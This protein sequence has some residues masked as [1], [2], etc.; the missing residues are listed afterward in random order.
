MATQ[1]QGAGGLN[2]PLLAAGG[3]GLVA[4]L[5]VALMAL[6]TQGHAAFNTSNDGVVWG[7]PVA[8]YVFFV[9]TSTGLT[10]VAS[11]AMVFNFKEFYPIAKRCVWLA[12]ATLIAGFASLALELGHP[13]RMLW[14]IPLSF[15]VSSA[16]NW[17]GVLYALYLVLLLVKF[18]R[19]EGGDWDSGASRNFGI[20]AFLSVIAAHGTLGLAFGM[21]AMR[22]FWYD[23]LLPIYFLAT[24]FLSGVAF[25]VLISYIAYGLDQDNMPERVRSLMTGAMPKLFATVLGIVILFV[26]FRTVTGLW[27]NADGLEVFHHMVASPWFWVEIIAMLVAFLILLSPALRTQGSMQL[28]ASLLVVLAL[29]IGRYEFVIGGQ[30]VPLFKGTW[31]EGI[32]SYTPSTTEWM[33]ALL[34]VSLMLVIYAVGERM[35]NLSAEPAPKK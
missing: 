3:I 7:L 16:M 15:Q 11:L 21:M 17:M 4:S 13:F 34:A 18:F 35:F 20:A 27:S 32:I 28:A 24:A 25:A 10:L 30:V 26:A 8:V 19:I 29:A 6:M 33:L 1:M 14:A 12:A 31:V 2:T 9:L 23:G 22:P 5:G